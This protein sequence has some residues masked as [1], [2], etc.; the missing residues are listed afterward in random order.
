MEKMMVQLGINR[1]RKDYSKEW[2][3]AT[4]KSRA[5]KGV[6]SNSYVVL[7]PSHCRAEPNTFYCFSPEYNKLNLVRHSTGTTY[8]FGLRLP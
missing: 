3:Q 7:L 8:E 4:N 5:S 1:P 6:S 2:Q